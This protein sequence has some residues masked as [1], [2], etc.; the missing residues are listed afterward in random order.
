M[1]YINPFGLVFMIFIMI[2]NI[3]FAIKVKDGFEN[4]S[5]NKLVEILEQIG[6]YGCFAFMLFNI[7][8]TCFGFSSNEIFALYLIVN[9]ILIFAYC[10]IWIF[11]F[12]KNTL[13]KAISLSVLPSVIFLFS[14]ILS[15]DILL[16]ISA[17]IFAPCHIFISCKNSL[18]R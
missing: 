17:L 4:S 16:I 7:P 10:L 5:K 12:N 6:R 8:G 15:R 2:P 18:T 9:S 11:L 1:S 14:G 3:I 13:F